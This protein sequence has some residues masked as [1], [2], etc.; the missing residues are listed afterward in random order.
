[1]SQMT[2]IRCP[3]CGTPLRRTAEPQ[4]VDCLNLDCM[5][6]ADYPVYLDDRDVLPLSVYNFE[7]MAYGRVFMGRGDECHTITALE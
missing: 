4:R 6:G 3:R 7:M 2:D 1:M 5:F